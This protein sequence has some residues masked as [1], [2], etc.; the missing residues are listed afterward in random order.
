MRIKSVP[1][2]DEVYSIMSSF[3]PDQ[4]INFVIG[5]LN[6]V[7]SC[8]KRGVSQIINDNTDINFDINC[9]RGKLAKRC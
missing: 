7:C 9:L 5:L 1:S 3:D 2:E 4:F 8:R 6:N